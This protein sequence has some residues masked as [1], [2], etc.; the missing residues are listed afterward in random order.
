MFKASVCCYASVMS[1]NGYA[2]LECQ[3]KVGFLDVR[4]SRLL[5]KLVE[6]NNNRPC[7]LTADIER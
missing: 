6:R 7:G 1:E 4:T 5:S 2:H 3:A